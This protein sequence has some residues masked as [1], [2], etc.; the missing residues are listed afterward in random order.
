MFARGERAFPRSF[1]FV[2]TRG[3]IPVLATSVIRSKISQ[4]LLDSDKMLSHVQS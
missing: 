3:R 1:F 2:I 4:V